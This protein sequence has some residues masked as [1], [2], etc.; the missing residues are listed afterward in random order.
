M[1]YQQKSACVGLLLS[2]LPLLPSSLT[3][4]S[5]AGISGNLQPWPVALA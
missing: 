1:A 3:L 5:S 4:T 2:P